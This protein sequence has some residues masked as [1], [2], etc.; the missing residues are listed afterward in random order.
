MIVGAPGVELVDKEGRAVLP[1]IRN[2]S[3]DLISSDVLGLAMSDSSLAWSGDLEGGSGS[4]LEMVLFS[5][6]CPGI[7]CGE[8]IGEDIVSFFLC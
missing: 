5:D 1:P 6:F 4:V 7:C 2:F 3:A 8:A